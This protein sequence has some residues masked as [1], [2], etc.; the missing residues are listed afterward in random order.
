M[1]DDQLTTPVFVNAGYWVAQ[2]P[3]PWCLGYDHYGPGPNTGRV[4]LLGETTLTCPRCM[5]VSAA[6]WPDNPEDIMWT[7]TQRPMPETRNWLPTETLED[8]LL[9]NATHG[10]MPGQL[11]AGQDLIIRGEL[12]EDRTVLAGRTL[13]AI[14]G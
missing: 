5:T 2:C 3:Q 11:L 9:E 1:T 4:G 10:L 7:L 6:Q 14:G 8:L 12:F 13:H